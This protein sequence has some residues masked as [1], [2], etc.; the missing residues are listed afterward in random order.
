VSGITIYSFGR[1]L[2]ELEWSFVATIFCRRK[3]PQCCTCT[4][5][6]YSKIALRI[7]FVSRPIYV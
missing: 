6:S 7:I 2:L 4:C 1:H 5:H 3:F